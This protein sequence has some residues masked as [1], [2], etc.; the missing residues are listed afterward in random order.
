[1]YSIVELLD[2]TIGG[3]SY[4]HG[5]SWQFSTLFDYAIFSI[6]RIHYTK[7]VWAWGI[8]FLLGAGIL[9][10]FNFGSAEMK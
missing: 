8:T 5:W 1:M 7:P 2:H 4:Q 6:I 9:T 10:V 3:I